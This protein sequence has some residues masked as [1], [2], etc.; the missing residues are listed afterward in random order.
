M[1]TLHIVQRVQNYAARLILRFGKSEHITHVLYYPH[2]LLVELSVE[3][4]VLLYTYEA[5]YD[6]NNPRRQLRSSG[7]CMLVVQKYSTKGY[8][9]HLFVCFSNVME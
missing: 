4:K 8:G 7:K 6:L 9:A 1:K 2:W 5:F 3:Y